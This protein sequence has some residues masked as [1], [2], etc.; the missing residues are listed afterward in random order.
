MKDIAIYGA[1]GF[2]REVKTI[3]QNLIEEG[4]EE[5]RFLGY[6][7]DSDKGD[8]L[9]S[10]YLGDMSVLNNWKSD[11]GVVIAV[12]K[13]EVR[14]KIF[15]QVNNQ[16]IDFPSIVSP[17][18]FIGDASSIDIKSGVIIAAGAN[19]TLDIC[20][21]DFSVVNLNVTIG[22]DVYL[23][24]F[25]SIMP[26]AHLSGNVTLGE[27]AFIGSGAVL[28]NNISV[29]NNSIVGAGAVVNQSV[30]DFKTVIGV[31]AKVYQE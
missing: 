25:S 28:L 7:D 21:S 31:P 11:L 18:S 4:H 24:S 14:K 30:E 1:G 20:I 3:I 17:K 26:G 23:N 12:G 13:G 15:Q 6:F 2:G 27:C 16:Y 29:G 8:L 19:L 10:F 22:H 5:W 9:G